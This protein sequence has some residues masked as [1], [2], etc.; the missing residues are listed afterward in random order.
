[1]KKMAGRPSSYS[2]NF[3]KK[4]EPFR[5]SLEIPNGSSISRTYVTVPFCILS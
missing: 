5:I 1:M 4:E 2:D 3:I